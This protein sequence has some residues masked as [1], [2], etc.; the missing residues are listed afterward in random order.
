MEKKPLIP[1]DEGP[2]DVWYESP[3]VMVVNK[4]KGITVHPKRATIVSLVNNS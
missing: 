4:S 2:L 3:S 1:I